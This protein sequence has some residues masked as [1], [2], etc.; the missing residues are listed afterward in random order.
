MNN[1]E[2]YEGNVACDCPLRVAV[3]SSG[4]LKKEVAGFFFLVGFLFIFWCSFVVED[5]LLR[6]IWS[7]F[8]AWKVIEH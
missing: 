8:H 3:L 5:F 6:D 4:G 7:H 1:F 2:T